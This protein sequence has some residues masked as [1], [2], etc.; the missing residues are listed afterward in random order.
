MNLKNSPN[1]EKY[2]L[3]A[4]EAIKEVFET[5]YSGML[6]LPF[7]KVSF[8]SPEQGNYNSGQYFITVGRNWQIHL[9]F[10]KLPKIYREFQAEV[11]V[12]TRHEIEH[13]RTCPFDI[14]TH[15]RMIKTIIDVNNHH[16]SP[17]DLNTIKQLAP[18]ISNQIADIIID[19]NNYFKHPEDT[20]KSE[21]NWIIKGSDDAFQNVSRTGKLMFLLK[22]ALWKQDLDLNEKDNKINSTVKELRSIIEKGGI[23]NKEEFISK[24]EIYTNKFLEMFHL[25]TIDS[26]T[27]QQALGD[28]VPSKDGGEEGESLIISDP[29]KVKDAINQLAQE[30]SV[31][32]FLDI[33]ES[34]GIKTLSEEEKE[35][36]WFEAQNIDEIPLVIDT[37]T[38]SKNELSFPSS[39]NIGDPVE[40]LDLLLTLQSMPKILPGISTKK[41]EKQYSSIKGADKKDSDLLLV[42]D[43]SGSMGSIKEQGSRL[44]EAVLASF[45]F[46][47]YFENKK[48]EIA[49]VN[50]SSTRK[51]QNWTKQYELIKKLLL[52]SWGSGTEFPINSIENLVEEKKDNLVIVVMTDGEI[53]N[54]NQTFDLFKELLQLRNK[55]FLFLMDGSTNKDKYDDLKNYGGFVEDVSTVNEIRN[56]VFSEIAE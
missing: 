8:L 25:D 55:V 9:N 56:I 12:L 54:W 35:I 11:K 39:W 38:K 37:S 10:G 43:T 29:D 14:L 45:G 33:L 26:E 52:F 15:L 21:I 44:N 46:V 32:E 4:K 28:S 22:E 48:A 7:P 31:D 42:I 27:S 2:L 50:Y 47:K 40:D 24:T 51:T 17:T 6:S 30:T 3:K 41:W 53:Q 13:Y 5:E 20:L 23:T 1:K 49:L 19:T 34:S 18:S 36:V 16:V